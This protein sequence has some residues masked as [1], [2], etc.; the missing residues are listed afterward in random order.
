[1]GRNSKW[2][3]CFSLIAFLGAPAVVMA[4]D[5]GECLVRS[6]VRTLLPPQDSGNDYYLTAGFLYE[7]VRL[8]GTQYAYTKSGNAIGATAL[9]AGGAILEP[10]FDASWGFTAGL[11]YYFCNKNWTLNARFDY[12]PSTGTANNT[13]AYNSNIVPVNIWRDQLFAALSADLGTAGA[14]TSRFKVTYYNL[15]IDL[16]RQ[17]YIDENFSLEPHVGL[18]LSFI[19][20]HVTTKFTGNGYDT[21]FSSLTDMGTNVL[22]RVQDSQF[23]GIGPNF[24]INSDWNLFCDISL[25]LEGSASILLGYAQETDNVAYSGL[26][27]SITKSTSPD[28]PVFSPA[29]QTLIGF[30]YERMIYCDTQRIIAKLG[31]DSSIYW[32]QWNHIDTVSESTFNSSLD[33]FQIQENDMFGLTGLMFSLTW[34]F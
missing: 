33:T 32:N 1:M 7:Q 5:C 4:G 14:S 3:A 12:L 2:A 18:K 20:D 30:K 22:S 17:L 13:A 27:T 15:N 10:S 28:S 24:G 23:W 11:A 19:Y 34:N 9:P 31:W 21:S 8:T 29:I 6:K 25:F 16:D 26:P